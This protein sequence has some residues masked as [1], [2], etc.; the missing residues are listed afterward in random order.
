MIIYFIVVINNGYD[1][2]SSKG[3]ITRV[4]E[5]GILDTFTPLE[6]VR[7]Q[8]TC[9]SALRVWVLGLVGVR[10]CNLLY[11]DSTAT[12]TALFRIQS[13]YQAHSTL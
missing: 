1:D 4:Q 5:L 13:F 6:V 2:D 8:Q 3:Y 9:L 7:N 11:F 10:A 12:T